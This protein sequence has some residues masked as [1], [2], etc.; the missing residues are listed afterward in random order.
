MVHVT[1]Q[2]IIGI[3]KFVLQLNSVENIPVI[4]EGKKDTRALR[5][6][7]YSGQVLEFHRFKGMVDFIDFVA[8]YESVI[9]LFDNDRK[10]TYLTRKTIELLQRRTKIDLSYKRKLR[11]ITKNKIKFIEQLVCYEFLIG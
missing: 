7:G 4:V 6:I 5:K 10:G 9:I 8:K 2:E 11:E 3:K 1:E